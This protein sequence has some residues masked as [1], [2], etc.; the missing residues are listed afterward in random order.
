MVVCVGLSNGKQEGRDGT[1]KLRTYA[2][3]RNRHWVEQKR[4]DH[5]KREE[6]R[7]AEWRFRSR[8][9]ES[10]LLYIH[11]FC[12]DIYFAHV[13]ESALYTQWRFGRLRTSRLIRHDEMGWDGMRWGLDD[14]MDAEAIP[15]SFVLKCV[16]KYLQNM[17]INLLL[18]YLLFFL[19]VPIAV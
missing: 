9:D 7:I 18:A 11:V 6:E 12:C 19:L 5:G 1:A 13:I 17:L 14:A 4:E 3:C 16:S 15:I 2:R 8:V 10:R